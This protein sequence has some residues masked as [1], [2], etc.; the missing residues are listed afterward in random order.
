MLI[1]LD[2]V[3]S[4]PNDPIDPEHYSRMKS[5]L[6]D[7][8][9]LPPIYVVKNKDMFDIVDGEHRFALHKELGATH[10]RAL[11]DI[12]EE[13]RREKGLSICM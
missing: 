2:K 4:N 9:D 7:L 11:R 6:V 3:R 13:T 10:I 8:N 12:G 1:S 5:Q